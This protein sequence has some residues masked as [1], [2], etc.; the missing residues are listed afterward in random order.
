MA[1]TSITDEQK[2]EASTIAAI[3]AGMSPEQRQ[4]I[5]GLILGVK[6]A[7]EVERKEAQ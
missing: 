3:F 6:L 2:L 7:G 5:S 4:L 1:K